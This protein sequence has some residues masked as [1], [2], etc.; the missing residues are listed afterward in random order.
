MTTRVRRFVDY[1]VVVLVA[2]LCELTVPG[3]IKIWVRSVYVDP[4]VVATN[5][6]KIS[7]A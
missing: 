7:V 1:F 5:F 6:S 4:T 2:E 3:Q